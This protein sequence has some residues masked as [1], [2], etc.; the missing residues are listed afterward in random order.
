MAHEA[1]SA[2]L[3]DLGCEGVI[4]EEGDTQALKS[5]LPSFPAVEDTKNRID[6]FLHRLRDI[7]PEMDPPE[8]RLRTI[9]TRDWA[10]LWRRFF[11]SEKI[12]HRLTILPP[13]E[14]HPKVAQDHV[15][16]MDPGPAFG[17]GQHPTTRMC[18]MAMESIP[19]IGLRRLLD[20]GTGSGILA[21]YGAMLGAKEV[22]AI[23]IDPEAVRWAQRNAALNG[24]A[25]VIQFSTKPVESCKGDFSVLTA[26]IVLHVILEIFP[27]L[28][29]LAARDGWLILSGILKEQVGTLEEAL[30][31][32]GFD[33]DQTFSQEDWCCLVARKRG[34]M[35][36]G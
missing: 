22:L 3:F 8:V 4:S 19:Q 33:H 20:V 5:Y 34:G 27:H 23:D 24:V 36:K 15:M 28:L 18:L 26:N 21:I 7:F 35:E 11:R 6:I 10:L 13:W 31:S 1:V 14:L 2:F 16:V 17:T 32:Y 9:E 12:T 29:S 30:T 25:S